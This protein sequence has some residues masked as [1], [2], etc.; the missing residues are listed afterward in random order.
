M[1]S[2]SLIFHLRDLRYVL[3]VWSKH[4][5]TSLGISRKFIEYEHLGSGQNH[6]ILLCRTGCSEKNDVGIA[7]STSGSAML[8]AFSCSMFPLAPALAC[9]KP[10]SGEIERLWGSCHRKNR[11]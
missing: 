10:S 7:A 6:I 11:Y 8:L 1:N 5:K 9:A 3:L 4:S 2:S